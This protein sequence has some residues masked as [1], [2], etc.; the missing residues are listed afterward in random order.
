[1]RWLLLIALL[2]PA[3]CAQN[4][5][6]EAPVDTSRA[7]QSAKAGRYQEANEIYRELVKA[8]P[9]NAELRIEW[10]RFYLDRFQPADAADA[11][12]EPGDLLRREK[13]VT[14]RP[15]PVPAFARVSAAC[16]GGP[17]GP[18]APGS[19]N[20]AVA[21]PTANRAARLGSNRCRSAAFHDQE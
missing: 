20:L 9:K 8:N 13:G 11:G 19:T 6:A 4:R 12:E 7:K 15:A 14:L 17:R 2:A 21:A 5:A 10:G 1:M 3:G 18:R 16:A